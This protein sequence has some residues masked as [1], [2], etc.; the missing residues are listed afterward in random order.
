MSQFGSN[1]Y[2]IETIGTSYTNV[3]ITQTPMY[4]LPDE[5]LVSV[6][7]PTNLPVQSSRSEESRVQNIRSVGGHEELDLTQLVK[8]VHLVQQLHES[9]LNLS[10]S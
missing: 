5:A 10:V 9:S 4:H 6:T 3:T 7:P 8:S 2:L 1:N